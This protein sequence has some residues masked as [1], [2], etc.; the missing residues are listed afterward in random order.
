MVVACVPGPPCSMASVERDTCT[1]EWRVCHVLPVAWHHL[2]VHFNDSMGVHEWRGHVRACVFF[3]NAPSLALQRPAVLLL[4]PSPSAA[5]AAAVARRAGGRGR[6]RECCWGTA[7]P[8]ALSP[9]GGGG[10]WV[11]GW[12]GGCGWVSRSR[13]E[14]RGETRGKQARG[15]LTAAGRARPPRH[16]SAT[17]PPCGVRVCCFCATMLSA[18]MMT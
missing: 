11:G 15:R 8:A 2:F 17:T 3:F 5:A 9:N 13:E 10:R 18:E 4:P 1:G 6:G 7:A 16:R 14:R 12:V